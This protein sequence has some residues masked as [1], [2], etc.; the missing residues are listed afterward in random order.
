ML[1]EKKIKEIR[2]DFPKESVQVKK[3]FKNPETGE[4]DY[5]TGYKPQYIFERLNDV[6]GHDGWNYEILSHGM[7]DGEKKGVADVWVLGRLTIKDI[8]V[9]DQFGTG[10]YNKGTSIGDALKSAATNALEKCA[11]LKDI[12]H[13]AY[14]GLLEVPETHPNHKEIKTNKIEKSKN[15]VKEELAL[16]C[17]KFNINKDSFPTLV[18]TVLKE[19]KNIKDITIEE[20]QKLIEHLEKY[21]APF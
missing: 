3:G 8:T 18:K 20:M 17:K 11:S 5:L 1:E 12:G 4:Q 7:I 15:I 6:F 19:E 2:A 13:I 10:S 16:A 21:G 14:K 9:V